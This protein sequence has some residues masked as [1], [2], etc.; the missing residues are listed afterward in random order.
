M[1]RSDLGRELLILGIVRRNPMS[2]YSIDRTV[3]NH[4]PL[5]R[6]FRQGNVYHLADRLVEEGCFIRRAAKAKRGPMRTKDVLHLSG[7]GEVRFHALLRQILLDT[8]SGDA[9]LEVALVLLGQLHRAE[10]IQLLRER[11][12]ELE[13]HERRLKRL[14]GAEGRSGSAYLGAS[15]A[16]HRL[17]SERRFLRE[18][19]RRLENVRWN[20]EWTIDDGP[21]VDASRKL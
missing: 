18:A 2:A 3:R 11:N 12:A 7:A 19:L 20:P 5:Y 9:M 10:A 21:I 17:Q 8:Q 14:F 4:A 15:H 1:A 16:T 13:R 6:P